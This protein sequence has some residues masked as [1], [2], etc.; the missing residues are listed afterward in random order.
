MM[1]SASAV[2][3]SCITSG[4]SRMNTTSPAPYRIETN[5]GRVILALMPELNEV[6]WADIERIG[7][8]LVSRLQDLPNPALLVDLC[9]LNYMGSAQVA[10]VVRLFKTVKERGGRMVVANRDAMVQE[11]L[12]LAGLDKLW[13]ISPS[14]EHGLKLLGGGHDEGEELARGGWQGWAG[15]V[16]ILASAAGLIAVLTNASWLPA[17]SAVWLEFGAAAA[18]FFFGLWSVLKGSGAAR[19]LGAGVLVGS[20]ALMLNSVFAL[21]SM[22]GPA[23]PTSS[24][25]VLI[26]SP[27][28]NPPARNS[29]QE[30][31]DAAAADIKTQPE[32]PAQP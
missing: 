20:L 8:E 31:A 15:V 13:T 9:A 26:T 23:K 6:P 22:H 28:M 7:A 5:R 11:V 24:A 2:D 27:S 14:P 1:K 12:T 32:T 21:G 19:T 25:P 16:C 17:S 30:A 18:G 4:P 10:L 3:E 29:M